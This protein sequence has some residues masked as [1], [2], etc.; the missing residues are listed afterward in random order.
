MRRLAER[1]RAS[2]GALPETIGG[3][4]VDLID[5]SGISVRVVAGTHELPLPAQPPHTFNFGHEMPRTNVT[6]RPP[7]EPARVQ[8]LGHVVLQTTKYTEALNWYLDNL[9]MIVSDFLLL[10]RPA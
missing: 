3:T 9:G 4:A 7:R 10:P 6:Q 8:R 1:D 2:D 5:P